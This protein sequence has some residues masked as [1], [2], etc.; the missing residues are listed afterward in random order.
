MAEAPASRSGLAGNL[1]GYPPADFANTIT[2][3]EKFSGNDKYGTRSMVAREG[4]VA[5]ECRRGRLYELVCAHGSGGR[6]G[7]KRASVGSDPVPQE[8]DPGALR[9]PRPDLLAGRDAGSA[10]D[11]PHRAHG[12]ALRRARQG[13]YRTGRSTPHRGQWPAVA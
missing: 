10:P 7:R 6:A 1:Q 4:A 5:D 9:R 2:H 12:D 13:S 8:L 11:R 3:S